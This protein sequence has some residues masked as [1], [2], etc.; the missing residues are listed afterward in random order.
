MSSHIIKTFT[1]ASKLSEKT[2][3]KYIR[4][5]SHV[6]SSEYPD[7]LT[8]S[9]DFHSNVME[10]LVKMTGVNPFIQREKPMVLSTDIGNLTETVKSVTMNPF[11]LKSSVIFVDDLT[12]TNQ[13]EQIIG[14][15]VEQLKRSSKNSYKITFD[16]HK[17]DV[18]SLIDS[19]QR[20]Y[21]GVPSNDS[22]Y[23]VEKSNKYSY[24]IT[25]RSNVV[26]K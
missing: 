3:E 14:V 10:L 21:G 23:E 24:D 9:D 25:F 19:I 11:K 26:I 20:L 18:S 4:D 15:R 5:A 6:V 1:K 12:F 7:L 8:E 13:L 16:E 2:I 17:R 22:I